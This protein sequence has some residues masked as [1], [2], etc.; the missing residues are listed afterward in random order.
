MKILPPIHVSPETAYLVE[1]Y[2]Y[3]FKLRC[4]I[5]Y[6]LEVSKT[7]GVR[8]C[9]QTTN[10][11]RG[12]I[13]NKPKMSTYCKFS[14]AMFLDEKDHVQWSGCHEYMDTADLQKWRETYGAGNVIPEIL[15]NWIKM[16]EKYDEARAAG[17]SMGEAALSAVQ[18][19]D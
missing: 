9:S 13:W 10:P 17:K 18:K 14:G 19:N 1:S 7:K 5:R 15:N 3:G 4:K 8:F 11:K 6:W 2:P 12:N 16:K